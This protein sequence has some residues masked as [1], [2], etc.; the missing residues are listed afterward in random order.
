MALGSTDPGATWLITLKVK[1]RSGIAFGQLQPYALE[2]QQVQ[3]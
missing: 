1:S 3:D 2:A